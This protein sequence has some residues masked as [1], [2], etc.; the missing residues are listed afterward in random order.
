MGSRIPIGTEVQVVK[1]C[2][3]RTVIVDFAGER[4][5]TKLWCLEKV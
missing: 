3:R 2:P 5:I 1:F 4:I